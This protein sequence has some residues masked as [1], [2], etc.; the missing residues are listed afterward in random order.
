M[1][2]HPW[3]TAA[4][5]LAVPLMASAS[6]HREAPN[7]SRFP[8]LDG[9]DLYLFNS[10]EAGRTGYVT[11]LADYIPL[12]DPYGGPNYFA[13]DQAGLYE[14]KIDNTGDAVEDITF[15]FQFTNTLAN[16]NAGAALNVGP[17]G[18]TKSVAVPLK[19]VR[20]AP[21]VRPTSIS[22]RPTR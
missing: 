7:I 6:S 2:K 14:I 15:Q 1:L 5:A 18:N 17:A 8:T 20:S 11:I 22:T 3:L 9:T 10:Y 21:R 4:V 13:L 19:N 16:A 12:Q